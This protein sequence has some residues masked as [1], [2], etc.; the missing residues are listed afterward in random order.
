MPAPLISLP[1]PST[2][3]SVS[4]S[5]PPGSSPGAREHHTIM[6]L[7]TDHHFQEYRGKLKT[8]AML[9]NSSVSMVISALISF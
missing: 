5:S 2:V 9:E 4:Q 7:T 1:S 3:P 6:S 8:V